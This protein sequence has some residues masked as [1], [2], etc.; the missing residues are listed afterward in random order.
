MPSSSSNARKGPL[1]EIH[2][3]RAQCADLSSLLAQVNEPGMT[4]ALSVLEKFIHKHKA[5]TSSAGSGATKSK[6]RVNAADDIVAV[7]SHVARAYASL[8]ND[9]KRLRDV[10]ADNVKFL[11]TL[12]SHFN[13]LSDAPLHDVA[14]AI[15]PTMCALRMVWI[16]SHHYNDD[17]RMG[18]LMSRIADVL[19]DRVR[20]AVSHR[21]VFA[22]ASKDGIRSALRDVQSSKAIMHAWKRE[23]L[24]AREKI[25]RSN[26]DSRWEFDRE[27][28]FAKSDY[29]ASVCEELTEMVVVAND[30]RTFLSPR[31]KAVTLDA[32]G[33][34]EISARVDAMCLAIETTSID[35][36]FDFSEA[37][38]WKAAYAS[39]IK[40]KTRIERGLCHFIDACFK[41]LRNIAGAFELVQ[42]LRHA[43]Y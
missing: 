9:V 28:L 3:W 16:I 19:V 32:D 5:T 4:M 33:V 11:S 1:A 22:R 24:L 20:S 7:V 37:S 17:S 12:E 21:D 13:A 26:R 14:Q 36:V 23:Y 31:L 18:A 6:T 35:D 8:V 27:R 34:D 25:E 30:F 15:A 38:R 39:F 43:M 29:A 41:R 10:G 40:E 2:H 42:E